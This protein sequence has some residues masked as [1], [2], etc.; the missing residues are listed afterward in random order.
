[1]QS[2]FRI[3]LLKDG[4]EQS[5]LDGCKVGQ[6]EEENQACENTRPENKQG[7]QLE[8]KPALVLSV[9]VSPGT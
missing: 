8:A 4:V 9:F 7:R 5:R 6:K 2:R 3:M 1:M